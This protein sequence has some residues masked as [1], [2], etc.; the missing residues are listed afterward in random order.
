MDEGHHWMCSKSKWQWRAACNGPV[1]CLAGHDNCPHQGDCDAKRGDHLSHQRLPAPFGCVSRCLHWWP[2]HRGRSSSPTKVLVTFDPQSRPVGTHCPLTALSLLSGF[3]CSRVRVRDDLK[4]PLAA[5][6]FPLLQCF[7]CDGRVMLMSTLACSPFPPALLSRDPSLVP[8][9]SLIFPPLLS[10]P[11]V[12]STALLSLPC[13]CS[14]KPSSRAS[15]S[16]S[17]LL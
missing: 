10:L 9:Q 12:Q 6:V 3:F 2:A 13:L 5:Q 7:G 17:S 15:L 4:V 8:P 16:P 11:G 1:C 14:L